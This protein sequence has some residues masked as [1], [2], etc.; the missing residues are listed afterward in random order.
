ME[1]IKLQQGD[2]ILLMSDGVFNTLSNA[3]IAGVIR[4]SA[5]AADAARNMEQR[6]L[7]KGAPN[8]DNFTCVILEI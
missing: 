8:Q 2:R 1:R 6:V 7:H 4:G 3:E 5:D